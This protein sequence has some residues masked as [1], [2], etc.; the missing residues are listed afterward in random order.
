MLHGQA[1][2]ET[3]WAF[4]RGWHGCIATR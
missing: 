3:T 4:F 2:L 1:C